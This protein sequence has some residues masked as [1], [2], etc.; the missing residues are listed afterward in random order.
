MTQTLKIFTWLVTTALAAFLFYTTTEYLSFRSDVHFLLAKTDV[1]FDIGWRSAFYIHIT[2]SMVI[3]IIAP[4]QFVKKLRNR[5]MKWHKRIGKIYAYGIVLLAGPSG[6]Y[7]AFYAEGGL[8]ST[9]AFI[10]MSV[11]WISTTILAVT[12]VRKGDITGHQRWMIRSVALT[13]A[14]VTLRLLVPL[15]SAGWGLEEGFV[16]VSTA[17]LSWLIN[18]AIAETI[19]LFTLPNKLKKDVRLQTN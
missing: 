17:W 19:I 16:I 11:L 18:L 1:V 2:S 12:T 5:Y 8:W 10:I 3:L 14:A 7:M 6:L 13:F 15:F 4:F 9:I